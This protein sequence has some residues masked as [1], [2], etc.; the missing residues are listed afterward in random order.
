MDEELSSLERVRR[1]LYSTTEPERTDAPTL[2]EK[3]AYETRGWER[4]KVSEMTKRS[5]TRLSWSVRFLIAASVLFVV[6]LLGTGA[7][8]YFG[9]RSVSTEQVQVKTEGPSTIA[10]GDTVPLVLSIDNKN[11]VVLREL[12]ATILY[13]DGTKDPEDASKPLNN[14]VERLGDVAPGAHIDKTV[15]ASVFGSEGAQITLLIKIEYKTDGSTSVFVIQKTFT[16]FV[17]SSP[18][19]LTISAPRE[20]ASGQSITLKAILKNNATTKLDNVGISLE[21]PFGFV[22]ASADPKPQGSLFYFA[23]LAPGEEKLITIT[24]TVAGEQNDER[25]FKFASGIAS[26]PSA[27]VLG[28]VYSNKQAQVVIAKPFLGTSLAIQNDTSES[29]VI[30]PGQSVQAVVEWINNLTDAVQ[31]AQV[32]IHFSGSALD[33]TSVTSGSGFYRSSDST[34]VF[35]GTTAASLTRL[36]A[37]ASGRASFNFK[38]KKQSVLA[39]LRSPAITMTLSISGERVG[40][41]T[42][43]EKI[44]STLTRVVRIRTNATLTSGATRTTGTIKNTGPWP[45]TPNTETTY[46]VRFTVQN[47]TNSVG[48]GQVTATLPNSV[49]YTGIASPSDGTFSFDSASRAVVW[50]VG[51][52]DAGASKTVSFQVGLTPSVS[53]SGFVATLVNPQTFTGTDRFTQSPIQVTVGEITTEITSDPA[54]TSAKGKVQ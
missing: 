44:T 12:T 39:S 49:R 14:V 9:G 6:T 10:S 48:G 26:S 47:T 1:R 53:Q 36:A 5:T 4:L 51:D 35:N 31:N 46:T 11:P 45:P 40:S 52:L 7:Y 20:T 16:F 24:G 22:L 32:T 37:G 15:R 43:P 29:P 25:V 28:T 21:Y 23:S 42:V 50:N 8:L 38:T 18:L 2:T 41:G 30:A 3:P 33:P 27:T 13:P 34:L 54:Y 19:S 17:T